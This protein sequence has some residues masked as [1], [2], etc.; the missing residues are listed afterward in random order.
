MMFD[1]VDMVSD[2]AFIAENILLEWSGI[3]YV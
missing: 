3:T 1:S 2:V